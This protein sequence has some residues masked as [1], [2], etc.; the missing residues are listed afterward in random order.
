MVTKSL[1][2]REILVSFQSECACKRFW[3]SVLVRLSAITLPLLLFVLSLW[4][5]LPFLPFCKKGCGGISVIF[6]SILNTMTP[7]V[8]TSMVGCALMIFVGEI[9]LS[10]VNVEDADSDGDK[11]G[12]FQ[13]R[14]VL[15]SV[16]AIGNN[17]GGV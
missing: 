10:D 6:E 9:S 14:M 12:F 4:S 16:A 2:R 7:K 1:A 15:V 17:S 5:G 11:K 3:N 8:H 13:G